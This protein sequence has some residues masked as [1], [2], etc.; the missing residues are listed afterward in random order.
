MAALQELFATPLGLLAL[1]AAV[2]IVVLY[3]VR[4]DPQRLRLPTL[5]FLTAGDDTASDR[6]ALSRL[7][8][9]LLL[10]LQL[11]VVTAIALALAS[12]YVTVAEETT[13]SET[14]LVVDP[15]ASMTVASDGTSRFDRAVR[16]ARDAVTETTSLVTAGARPRVQLRGGGPPDATAALD[17][18]EPTDTTGDLAGA[19][20]RAVAVAGPEARIVV[21][22]DVAGEGRWRDAVETARARGY[23]VQLRPVGEAVDNVGIVDAEYGRTSVTLAVQNTGDEPATRRVGYA[24]DSRRIELAPGDVTTVT[25]QV[26]PGDTR[27]RLEP[28][29]A[30]P[31]DDSLYVAGPSEETVDVLVVTNDPNRN[32]VTALEVLDEVDLT[33]ANPPTTVDQQYDVVVFSN[34]APD[35]LL[36][37]TVDAAT[38]TARSGGG[39]VIQAQSDLERVEYGPLLPVEPGANAS[40]PSVRV[41]DDSLTRGI[42]FP[43]PSDYLRANATGSEAV[44]TADGSPLVARGS[45]GE[46]RLLYYGYL[47]GSSFR[48]NY[49]YPVFWKRVVYEAAG[50]EPLSAAN[51]DT[52]GILDAP[53]GTTVEGP[54][55]ETTGATALDAAG[56]YRVGDDRYGVSL[57]SRSESNV[58]A[59]DLSG[60]DGAVSER[61]ETREV[62]QDRSF[63]PALAA[64]LLVVGEVGLLRYR[65]DL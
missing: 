43:P 51:R 23:T 2:P 12:P 28:G 53:N 6:P 48:Y 42:R 62:P 19:I 30:F 7:R 52:G 50:R 34:V 57:L 15:S 58:S 31:T 9:S 36:R 24:N 45:L 49:Q 61:T 44:V 8:R 4:P 46:G 18:L 26:P 38:E 41:R 3:L 33:V 5:A 63:V 29:D 1:A 25:F 11:L 39:V 16:E 55:G 27:F 13:V 22:S 59:P 35:R 65:G 56:F 20:S 14:V 47:P 37:S 64:L 32:L 21:A 54:A 40:N 17:A 10:L 60:D